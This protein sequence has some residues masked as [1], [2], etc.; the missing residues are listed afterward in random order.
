M[1]EESSKPLLSLIWAQDENRLIGNK[2]KLPWRLPADLAWF[3]EN[4]IG[5]PILMGRKTF[6]SIGKPL[7]D[8][9]NIVLTRQDLQIEGCTVVH[10]LEQARE[11]A[12]E[13]A[14][15]MVIGGAEIYAQTLPFAD[16]LYYTQIHHAFK[17]DA[18]FL[19]LNMKMWGMLHRE[20]HTADE[21]N[22]YDH[23]FM[24]LARRK[25]A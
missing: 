21:K 13:A 15:I 11:A 18:W 22:P 3:K 6:E 12:G 20:T 17:G 2:N 24:I 19:E 7:P 5:K 14:E 23:T 8:R 25:K 16:K 10:S 9:Q 1:T 4:T